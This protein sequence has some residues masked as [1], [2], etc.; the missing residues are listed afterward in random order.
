M[1]YK[2]FLLLPRHLKKMEGKILVP[3]LCLMLCHPIVC[4]WYSL[5]GILEWVAYII[6]F[7]GFIKKQI[8]KTYQ[9]AIAHTPKSETK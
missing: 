8:Y 5:A 7:P 1:S 9:T 3:Q 4:P 6:K 2:Y